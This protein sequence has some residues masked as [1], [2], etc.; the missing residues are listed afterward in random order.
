MS[1]S[2]GHLPFRQYVIA[3][4][5]ENHRLTRLCSLLNFFLGSCHLRSFSFLLLYLL[6]GFALCSDFGRGL[7]SHHSLCLCF[8][9]CLA[10][11][12]QRLL[13]SIADPSHDSV[14]KSRTETH[15][16]FSLALFLFQ[17][18]F[19][20]FLLVIFLSTLLHCL[21][22]WLVLLGHSCCCR[23]RGSSLLTFLSSHLFGL[24]LLAFMHILLLLSYY[25]PV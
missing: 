1:G 18:D 14:E 16:F 20:L 8:E 7:L 24:H 25:L 3:H 9:A 2:S 15:E 21:F 22:E 12:S 19:S 17:I 6:L 10:S 23:C 11:Q 13:V 4:Y 5:L